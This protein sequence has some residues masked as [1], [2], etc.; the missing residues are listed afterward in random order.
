MIHTAWITALVAAAG[1]AA[2]LRHRLRLEEPVLDANPAYRA[3]MA[4]KPR[5]CPS[6][7]D[8][9][10]AAQARDSFIAR[11]GDP[12][13]LRRPQ[14]VA[15]CEHVGPVPCGRAQRFERK[16]VVQIGKAFE[17]PQARFE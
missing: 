6:C 12:R 13:H 14:I 11:V 7:F 16:L 4:G 10:P 8:L 2:V 17:A 15:S 1:N 5:F 3:A 9:F